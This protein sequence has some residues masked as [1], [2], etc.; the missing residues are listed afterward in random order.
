MGTRGQNGEE[1]VVFAMGE[2]SDAWDGGGKGYKDNGGEDRTRRTV[3]RRF[4]ASISSLSTLSLADMKARG[5]C[6][7]PR[8]FVRSRCRR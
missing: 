1:N 3:K 4:M 6:L 7:S 5:C 2:D 8:A